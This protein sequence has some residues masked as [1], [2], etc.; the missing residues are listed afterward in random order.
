[1]LA[2]S[3]EPIIG[4][5]S[6]STSPLARRPAGSQLDQTQ[7]NALAVIARLKPSP[8][9]YPDLLA[10][11]IQALIQADERVNRRFRPHSCRTTIQSASREVDLQG[12]T[13]SRLAGV[14]A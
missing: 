11:K 10:A 5:K 9:V 13:G 3:N 8:D 14:A 1:V 6:V 12:L 4:A 7:R 2:I